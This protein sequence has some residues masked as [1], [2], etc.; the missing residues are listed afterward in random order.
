VWEVAT[1]QEIAR[2]DDFDPDHVEWVGGRRDDGPIFVVDP[3]PSWPA[4]FDELAVRVRQ[5]LGDRVLELE[6]VGSTSV[7]DLPAKPVIDIDLTVVDSSD[8]S[9]YVPDLEAVGF[10]LRIR[11]PKWHEHRCMVAAS[12]RANLHVWSPGSPEPIRHRLFRD[13]LRGHPDDRQRYA[14]AKRVSADDA[15]AAHEDVMAYNM[16]K[17]PV[18]RDILDRIFQANGIV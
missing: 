13:W 14:D 17:Q 2:H 18:V 15:N 6:H 16:R 3:D 5:A 11:E 10:V 9:A 1:S 7:P 8:E 4:H 12:P